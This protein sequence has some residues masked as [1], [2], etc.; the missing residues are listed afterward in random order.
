[1]DDTIYAPQPRESLSQGDI[2]TDVS[3]A[4]P[5]LGLDE[6]MRTVI[7]LSHDCEIDKPKNQTMIVA[8]VVP[9][10]QFPSEQHDSIRSGAMLSVFYLADPPTLAIDSC[11]DFR[12]TFR[13]SFVSVGATEFRLIEDKRQRI[14]PTT[15]TRI[16]SLSD[17]GIAALH[18]RIVGFY[19]RS[20]DFEGGSPKQPTGTP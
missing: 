13:T 10:A 14:L 5:H 1:M 4:E 2:L 11:V 9:L 19:T 6:G 16:L 7:V 8:A 15:N 12:R 20:R 18:G 3:I 17:F